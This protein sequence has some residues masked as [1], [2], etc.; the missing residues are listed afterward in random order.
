MRN[1]E[2]S[3][4]LKWV[5]LGLLKLIR[6]SQRR[7]KTC[8]FV[9]ALLFSVTLYFSQYL[10]QV[11]TIVDQ[12][13]PDMVT[14][15]DLR[16]SNEL[17]GSTSSL[18][19]IVF[20]KGEFFQPQELC[21]I[22]TTINDIAAKNSIIDGFMTPYK[23]REAVPYDG[24]ISYFRI[25]PDACNT[26]HFPS[27]PLERIQETPWKDVLTD[28]KMRDFAVHFQIK[29]LETPGPFKTFDPQAIESI[30]NEFDSKIDLEHFTTGTS[31]QQ[32]FTM[33]GMA[34]SQYL[35]LAVIV[36]LLLGFRL[37]FGTFKS[38]LI[39]VSAVVISLT[40]VLGLMVMLGFEMDPL[41]SSL[42]LMIAI[43]AIEDF[44]FISYDRMLSNRKLI[45]S[46]RHLILPCF[47]TSF[48]TAI[49]FASLAVSDL[50][51][52]RR[53]GSMA[54]VGAMIEWAVI[55]ILFPALIKL[56]P[57]VD[58]WTKREKAH[59]VEVS[60]R[61]LKKTPPKA[62][63]Y[64]SL[65]IFVAA[66]F[67][68][69]NFRLSQTPSEIFPPE[70]HFQKGVSYLTNSR[71]WVADA[72]LVFE[73][74]VTQER[75]AEILRYVSGHSFVAKTETYEGIK[76][77]VSSKVQDPLDKDYVHFELD[78]SGIGTRFKS[79]EGHERVTLYLKTTNT[80]KLNNFRNEI[81]D[82]CPQKECWLTGEFI[83]FAEYSTALIKTL[84]ESLMTSL[85]SVA[86]I[87]GWLAI[88]F[89][90]KNILALIVAT[91]WGP[92]W[93]LFMIYAFD[94]SINFITCIV[95]STLVGLAGDN[96][97]HFIC[98]S[99]DLQTG[100]KEKGIGTIQCAIIMA[101]C[102]ATMAG[103]YFEPPRMLGLLL[104]AGLLISMVGDLW[105]LKGLIQE[106]KAEG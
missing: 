11:V 4:N 85:I 40:S 49:G 57:K 42:F 70:H 31:A 6:L 27:N 89:R 28:S 59:F 10:V 79:D 45:H 73:P 24:K 43:S 17:F 51:S 84:F 67:A 90:R 99:D 35:N 12:L 78:H 33:K 95:A 18:G 93:M 21:N 92:A 104:T 88:S 72:S 1:S 58:Q 14:T 48:T 105:I 91:L 32:L 68:S 62:L 13:D 5:K 7:P 41:S 26:E 100:I 54:A 38:G 82:L 30:V 80:E 19:F 61:F 66:A 37:L 20:P 60:D 22:Q 16:R 47:L 64:L 101:L 34:Q 87:I 81:A 9:F 55:F 3:K 46:F 56:F 39:Y 77:F 53:F 94:L 106:D 98:T 102:C 50:Q 86:V 96:A 76:S 15:Q 103:S 63:T 2:M 97:V 75:K 29:E 8:V 71:G 74:G 36:I 65:L 69:Q 83:G 44:I 52:I 25:I 23:I